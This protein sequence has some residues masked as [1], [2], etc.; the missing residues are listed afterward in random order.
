MITAQLR[1]GAEAWV[2]ESLF[3]GRPMNELGLE[4]L[5]VAMFVMSRQAEKDKDAMAQ[6]IARRVDIG[7]PRHRRGAVIQ[8]TKS[9]D[10]G[11]EKDDFT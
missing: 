10:F 5:R 11:K 9:D 7:L 4:D 2:G 6:E 1:Y 3:E 8:I